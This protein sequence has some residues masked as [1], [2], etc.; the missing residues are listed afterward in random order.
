MKRLFTQFAA[1]LLCLGAYTLLLP[2][3]EAADTATA[4]HAPASVV[5]SSGAHGEGAAPA[6]HHALPSA[7]VPLVSIGPFVI[8]NSMLVTWIAALIMIVV[9]QTV[10]RKMKLVPEGV[11][12]FV[13]WLVESLYIFLEDILGKHLV[14]RTFWFFATLFIFILV[15][16]WIGLFPGV[17]TI[18]WGH[19]GEHGFVVTE[20]IFRGGNADLNMTGAMA[21]LFF[22]LWTVWAIQEV[23][24]KGVIGHVF[25]GDAS[26]T[27][28]MKVFLTLVFLVVGVLEIVSILFRPVALSLRLYGN[29]YAGENMIESM[30]VLVP[31]LGWALPLPFYFLELLVGLVQALVFCLLTA[32]FTAMICEHHH[33]EGH[34][35][36][37]TAPAH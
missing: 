20:P 30:I 17:G 37:S 2:T 15:T 7:A 32:V 21:I 33:E 22:F 14:K 12:N 27:G 18:G 35:A 24:V 3:L 34:E 6:D 1:L 16:N 13:E 25:G 9:A 29:M 23:G 19:A 5:D 10:S 8:T 36:P 11:Q 31:W 4:A 26:A 28:F